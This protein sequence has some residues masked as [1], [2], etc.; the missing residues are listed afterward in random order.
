MKMAF[1]NSFVEH[2][3][4]SLGLSA[5]QLNIWKKFFIMPR[6][7]VYGQ[8]TDFKKLK[9][10]VKEFNFYMN[11]RILSVSSEMAVMNEYCLSIGETEYKIRR[12]KFINVEYFNEYGLRR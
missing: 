5:P 8:I 3:V 10:I 9:N 11:P 7:F 6:N 4:Y 2:Q 12:P 1:R